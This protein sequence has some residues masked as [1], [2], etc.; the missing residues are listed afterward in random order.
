MK[1][2]KQVANDAKTSNVPNDDGMKAQDQSELNTLA[3]SNAISSNKL[4]R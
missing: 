1:L 4:G 3:I 2:S